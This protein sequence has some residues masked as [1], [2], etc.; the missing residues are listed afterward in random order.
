MGGGQKG[1]P[2]GAM[3][4]GRAYGARS[5]KDQSKVRARPRRVLGGGGEAAG[6]L[7]GDRYTTPS[8]K[9]VTNGA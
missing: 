4:E 3:K 5:G 9:G 1:S 8:G 7:T 2:A 6:T